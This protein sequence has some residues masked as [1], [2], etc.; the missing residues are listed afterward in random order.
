MRTARGPGRP[1]A[2]PVGETERD[3]VRAGER[4]GELDADQVLRRIDAEARRR[5]E[6]AT[7]LRHDL[8]ERGR[9]HH[10]GELALD[11]IVGQRGTGEHPELEGGQ[12]LRHDLGDPL[13]G[14]GRERADRVD[15]DV[16]AIEHIAELAR[17][18]AHVGRRDGEHDEPGFGGEALRIGGGLERRGQ[19]R[20][21]QAWRDAP[22][23]DRSDHV[24]IA[25]PQD[26]APA[27]ARE[28]GAER[29][30]ERPRAD[31]ADGIAATHDADSSGGMWA[32]RFW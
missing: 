22:V 15:H 10:R 32:V 9:D 4:G 17:T 2:Q 31:D 19:R 11:Q 29:G 12:P 18:I 5:V 24:G 3:G 26:H 21:R 28:H 7:A 27:G 30:A 14:G 23:L 25:R 6:E 20:L 1:D 13:V 16:T 8:V